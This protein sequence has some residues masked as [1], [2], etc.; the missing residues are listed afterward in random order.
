MRE[1]ATVRALSLTIRGLSIVIR[2]HVKVGVLLEK[3][4]LLLP[5]AAYPLDRTLQIDVCGV[6]FQ[7]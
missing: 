4:G 6:F 1:L 2:V 3:G 5:F 7:W